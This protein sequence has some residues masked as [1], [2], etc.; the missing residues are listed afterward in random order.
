M[1]IT[2]IETPALILEKSIFD[3]NRRVMASLLSGSTMAMRPHYKSHKCPAI[4]RIQLADGAKGFTCAKLSEA[5]DLARAGVSD[6]LIANQIVDEKKLARLAALAGQCRLTVCVESEENVLAL[7]RAASAA[8][9]TVYV[10]IEYEIGMKR[11]GVESHEEVLTLA[12]LISAQ[13]S[14]QFEGIQ[15]YAGNMAHEKSLAVRQAATDAIEADLKELKR[16]LEEA[17]LPPKEITGGSTGTVETKPGDSVYT[18]MQCGSYIFMDRAYR[19]LHIG[20]QNA[21]FLLTTVV[22]T[23]D[24]RIVTD[25]GV[26]SLGMDQGDPVFVGYEGLPIIMSEEHGQV[27]APGHTL[28]LND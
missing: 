20:F 27:E 5:E 17:G 8:G 26:K 28:T 3:Q 18:E 7:S 12:R 21:L 23:K 2:S 1:K 25:G 16:K 15:A 13:K 9:T 4:A 10:L 19:D 14:L 22:S 6:I 24:D 11:C